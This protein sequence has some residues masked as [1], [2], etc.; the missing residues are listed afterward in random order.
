MAYQQK[1]LSGSLWKNDKKREGKKDADYNGSCLINGE[2]FWMDSWIVNDPRDKA[3]YDP[4]KKTF[5]SISFRPKA[6]DAGRLRLTD[7][8][9]LVGV[10]A[11]YFKTPSSTRY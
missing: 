1:N 5:Q 4:Q 9:L 7:L 3:T 10:K 8:T 6:G 2:E 11:G